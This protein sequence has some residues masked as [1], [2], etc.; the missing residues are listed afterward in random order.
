MK[1]NLKDVSAELADFSVKAAGAES[2]HTKYILNG[3]EKM[4]SFAK[5]PSTGWYLCVT[6]NKA[7][8]F[9]PIKKQ[10]ITLVLIGGA[11][12]IIGS[13]IFAFFVGTLLK[14]L[15]LLYARVADVAEGEGDLTKRIDVGARKDE[16]GMLAEKINDFIGNIHSIIVQ[17]STASTTLTSDSEKLNSTSASISAGAEEVAAQTVTVATASEEM[18]ATSNDIANNCLMAAESAKQAA[19]TTQNGFR[20]V[21][22]TVEG[23]RQRGELTRQNTRSIS[24]LVDRS[25]QIGTIVATIEDIADQTNLL[26]LN[27]AIEAARAGEQGRG[28]AVVADEVRALAE[29]TTRATKEISTMIRAI[30]LETRNAMVS[31]EEGVKQ[32]DRG[33][34]EAAQIEDALRLILDQVNAV[35]TQVSQIAT[36]AEEQNATTNGITNNIHQ[37][38]EVVHETAKGSYET[39]QT[40]LHL[41]NLAGDLHRVVSKFRL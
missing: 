5:V 8:V 22:N 7:D 19:D 40:A 24:S 12:L 27:A 16:I 9:A 28:F 36:A 39:A 35:T 20:I 3:V 13:A 29:R 18:A 31:M 2:G 6:A 21:S 17:V 25:E 38:T 10:F 37:V 30:Q 4:M 23:I 34:D 1:K 32:S 41:S 33:I 26:A 15:G 14:P 11:L